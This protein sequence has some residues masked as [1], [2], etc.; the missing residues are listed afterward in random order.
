ML[1]F[2]GLDTYASIVVNDS[3]LLET[4]NAHRAY[5]VALPPSEDA[6]NI[7]ITLH[8]PVERGQAILDAQP[9]NIPVTMK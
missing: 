2:E 3:L 8:S 5:E 7:E 9:R 6:W 1:R 4:D